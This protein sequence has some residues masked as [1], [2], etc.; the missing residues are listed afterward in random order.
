VKDLERH[1]GAGLSVEGAIDGR[2]P[3]GPDL[4]LQLES[5]A[6]CG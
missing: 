5:I 2:H 4:T 1:H 3:P 6:Q